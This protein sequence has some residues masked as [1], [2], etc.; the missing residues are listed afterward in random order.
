VRILL[1]DG[2]GE[3]GTLRPGLSVVARVDERGRTAREA[4]P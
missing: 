3:L 1:E 2:A 4:R